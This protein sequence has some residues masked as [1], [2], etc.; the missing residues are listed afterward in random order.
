[1][2]LYGAVIVSQK[3]EKF[4]PFTNAFGLNTELDVLG[5]C[6]GVTLTLYN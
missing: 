6:L 3:L 1:M 4:K 2:T 5:K